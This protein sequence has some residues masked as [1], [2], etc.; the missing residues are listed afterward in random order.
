MHIYIYIFTHAGIACA[1]AICVGANV[2]DTSQMS[3]HVW[4]TVYACA[5]ECARKQQLFWRWWC[6]MPRQP[7]PTGPRRRKS[8]MKAIMT[9]LTRPGERGDIHIYICTYIFT[10][11]GIAFARAFCAG[12]HRPQ[13][14]QM[15]L[16]VLSNV[17]VSAAASAREQVLV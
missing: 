12:A 17:D 1:R 4:S 13:T 8:T 11:V 15:S 6:V 5:A 16:Y 9:E 2:A 3:L 7:A 10:H 14:N